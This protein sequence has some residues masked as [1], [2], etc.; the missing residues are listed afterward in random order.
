MLDHAGL[1][2]DPRFTV[3]DDGVTFSITQHQTLLDY[4]AD[5]CSD[6]DLLAF[7]AIP[8]YMVW[9]KLTDPRRVLPAVSRL[10]L[11]PEGLSECIGQDHS[12]NVS[13]PLDKIFEIRTNRSEHGV[14]VDAPGYLKGTFFRGRADDQAIADM[15]NRRLEELRE[16]EG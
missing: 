14:W 6:L 7:V 1:A 16:A 15:L 3:T 13:V 2:S 4:A 11:G 9:V 5:R 12:G 8:I 10:R